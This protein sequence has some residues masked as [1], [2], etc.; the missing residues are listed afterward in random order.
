MWWQPTVFFGLAA[1]CWLIAGTLDLRTTIEVV[2]WNGHIEWTVGTTTL[3]VRTQIDDVKTLSLSAQA[4]VHPTGGGVLEG[5]TPGGQIGRWRLPAQFSFPSSPNPPVGDWWVDERGSTETVFSVSA[6]LGSEFTLR[7]VITGRHHQHL[8]INL[9]GAPGFACAFRRGLLNNDLLILDDHG[10]V[11]ATGSLDPQPIDRL[12]AMISTVL[13]AV[14]GGSLLLALWLIIAG[15]RGPVA[16]DPPQLSPK[17][18][19]ICLTLLCLAGA[20]LAVWTA[21]DIFEDLPHLPDEVVYQLQGRWLLS[22][23]LTGDEPLCSENFT[24]PLTYVRSGRWIGHYPPLWPL[25]LA[26]GIAAGAPWLAPAFLRVPHILL[27][28]LLGLRLGGRWTALAAAAAALASPLALLLFGS[29][30]PHAGSATLLLGAILLCLPRGSGTSGWRWV[31]AG[32]A[33]GLAFGMRPLTAVAVALPVGL[34]QLRETLAGRRRWIDSVSLITS[35]IATTLP[36]LMANNIITGSPWTFPYSLAEGSMYSI[37]HAAFGIRNL[38]TL[39]ASLGPLAHGWG[40]PWLNGPVSLALPM[41]FVVVLFLSRQSTK[42]DRLLIAIAATVV[43]AHI[44]TRATGLHGFGPRY[45]FVPCGIAWILTARGAA[46]L[47]SK[48]RRTWPAAAALLCLLTFSATAAIPARLSLYRGYNDIN[49]RMTRA[50]STL[51]RCSLVLLP[52]DNWRGWAEASPWLGLTD[53]HAA[54]LFAADFGETLGLEW[55]YPDRRFYRWTDGRMVLIFDP[56][57]VIP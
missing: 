32:A 55:C 10:N 30:M 44:G 39:L 43:L 2:A 15:L 14:S 37:Q 34:Y 13:R 4:G 57:T 12:G 41:A 51:P 25:I 29:R 42:E 56:V 33:F 17:A 35:G 36:T 28:A 1:A 20:G 16:Q 46:V 6:D 5:F 3:R 49:P 22:G 54:P 7:G 21:V 26:P 50:A 8:I 19:T 45:L 48:E 38:D 24:V 27:I 40:W 52:Q 9:G 53:D 23:H 31:G 18:L 47:A 11:L